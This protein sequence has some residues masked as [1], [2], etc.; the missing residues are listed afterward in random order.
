MTE[1]AQTREVAARRCRHAER[2]ALWMRVT[3][4]FGPSSPKTKRPLVADSS[5]DAHGKRWARRHKR[6]EAFSRGSCR[7]SA[8]L[9]AW[10]ARSRLEVGIATTPKGGELVEADPWD[11]QADVALEGL[12]HPESEPEGDSACC[13]Y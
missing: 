4:S 6:V 5:S 12:G 2:R 10:M 7:S 1:E 3:T 9:R 13:A 8:R 11:A